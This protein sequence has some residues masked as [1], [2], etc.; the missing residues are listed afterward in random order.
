M[1]TAITKANLSEVSKAEMAEYISR[2][3]T[4][5]AR[6]RE[7]MAAATEALT[8]D[9]LTVGSAAGTGFLMGYLGKDGSGNEKLF[10]VD[11]DAIVGAAAWGV[12][13]TGLAGNMGGTLGAVGAG[14]LSGFASRLAMEQAKQM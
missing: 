8:S 1:A 4:K 12:S 5:M 13:V 10:G 3:K 9:L 14:A 7:K 2:M 11:I 6:D